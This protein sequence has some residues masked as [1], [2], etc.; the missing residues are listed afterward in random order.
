MASA[1][2]RL[3]LD[4][5]TALQHLRQ[6]A[7][8]DADVRLRGYKWL[9]QSARPMLPFL[10]LRMARSDGKDTCSGPVPHRRSRLLGMGA[11]AQCGVTGVIGVMPSMAWARSSQVPDHAM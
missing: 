10:G 8:A 7:C 4:R 1:T 6:G 2:S 5:A 9:R 11:S 3:P